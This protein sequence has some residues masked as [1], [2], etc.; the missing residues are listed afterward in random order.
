VVFV[1]FG[2]QSQGVIRTFTVALF[3]NVYDL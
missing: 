3:R 1:V 2:V